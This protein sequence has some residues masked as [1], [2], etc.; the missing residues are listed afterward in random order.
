MDTL[1]APA[2][3]R[4]KELRKVFDNL[5]GLTVVAIENV[6][7][8]VP[9][10]SFLSVV[11]PSGCGK[12][13]LLKICA[14][15]IP[16]TS[17][18]VWL[19]GDRIGGPSRERGLVFQSFTLFPWLTVSQ[20]VAFGSKYLGLPR[21]EV[22]KRTVELL[23]LVGL[24]D[25]ATFYPQALSGGMQQR[26]AIART[27]AAEPAVLLMDEPFGSLDTQ[28]RAFMQEFLLDIWAKTGKTILFVTHDV[29]EAVFLSDFVAVSSAR[30]ATVNSVET[31]ILPRPR[32]FEVKSDPQFIE[33]RSRITQKI[34]A[35]AP[36][37]LREERRF[38]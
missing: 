8:E 3:I 23:A 25:A 35:E 36:M 30:P 19:N 20:N 38:L 28:T 12:T 14:G 5:D 29:E 6:S 22:R 33:Y 11:G 17:G 24:S 4:V 37:A 2:G 21:E 13:T 18:E 15:L 32:R 27:L 1:S 34:R 9:P 31:I 26:A 16:P 10:G 7:L